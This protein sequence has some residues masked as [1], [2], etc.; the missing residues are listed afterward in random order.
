MYYI[1]LNFTLILLSLLSIFFIDKIPKY[2]VVYDQPDNYRKIHL[3]PVPLIGGIILFVSI[4]TNTLILH[5]YFDISIK[6]LLIFTVLLF[7][8]FIIG[9]LDDKFILSPTKKTF[10]IIFFLLLVLPL[11]NSFI[12]KS[13]LFKN[14]DAIIVLNETSVFFTVLCLYFIYNFLNFSDGANGITIS[15]CIFWTLVFIFFGNLNQF[16][17]IIILIWL[18]FVLIFNLSEKLFIG[19]SGSSFLSILFGVLFILNYNHDY[20]IKCDEILLMMFIP[21]VDSLRVIIERMFKGISPFHPDKTHLHHLLLVFCNAKIVFIPY[22]L[23]ASLPYVSNLYIDNSLY[24]LLISSVIYF[25]CI[26]FL[27]KL[28]IN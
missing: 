20:T 16:F 3:K 17:L 24:I 21:A 15:L 4:F 8:F 18:I 11:E 1:W 13:L 25:S 10:L 28:K 9:F 6:I 26:V 19:N 27:K 14:I 2:L 22:I 23:F 5:N 7:G 12:I